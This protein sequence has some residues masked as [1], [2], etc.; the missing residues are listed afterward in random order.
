MLESGSGFALLDWLGLRL[1]AVDGVELDRPASFTDDICN[2]EADM[3]RLARESGR[4]VL[5]DRVLASVHTD[6]RKSEGAEV[7]RDANVTDSIQQ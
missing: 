1:V 2:A 4:R 3:L 6:G 5:S 7:G